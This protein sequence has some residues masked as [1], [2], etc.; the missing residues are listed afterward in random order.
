M[1]C[2]VISHPGSRDIADCKESLQKFNWDFEIYPAV[3]GW[4]ISPADWQKIG[5]AIGGGKL[6]SRPGA[7]G[8]WHSHF[9][10][11]ERCCESNQDMIVLE[12]DVIVTDR[13]PDIVMPDTLVKLYTHAP[14]KSHPVYG[15]WSKG[16]HAYTLSPKCANDLIVFARENGAQALDKHLGDKVLSWQFYHKDLV[17]LNPGRARSTTS[18]T[19]RPW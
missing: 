10:L 4:L 5:V 1:K 6:A 13:C 19:R 7:Q 8:C 17:M 15:T 12:H 14:V 2:Y 18:T 11:W 9:R 16:S 3:D